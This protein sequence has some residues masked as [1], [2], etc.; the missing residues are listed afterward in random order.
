[1]EQLEE[2]DT[3]EEKAKVTVN[4]G[5]TMNPSSP[6]TTRNKGQKRR[7]RLFMFFVLC[8]AVWTG[9]TLYLQS[10]A[11]AEK[12]AQLE[13]LKLEAAAVQQQQAE[14]TYKVSRLNDKEYIAE[15]ARKHFFYTKPGETIYVIP[16]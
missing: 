13:A 4:R 3:L 8:I 6:S 1:L 5:D 16:E 12:E 9:Y 7:I 11:L 15:L 2:L 14:L 10:D